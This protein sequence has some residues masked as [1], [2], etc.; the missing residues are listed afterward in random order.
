VFSQTRV[1][2]V[3]THSEF[4]AGFGGWA[5]ARGFEIRSMNALF[6]FLLKAIRVPIFC[7]YPGIRLWSSRWKRRRCRALPFSWMGWR[8]PCQW[9]VSS[10][11]GAAPARKRRARP[12]GRRKDGD[13]FAELVAGVNGGFDFVCKSKFEI[14]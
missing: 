13:F 6:F 7:H 11:S 10:E 2:G 14:G 3:G 4:H 5:F 12:C 1:D 8:P 9:R